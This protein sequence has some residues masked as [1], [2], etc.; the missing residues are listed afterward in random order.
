MVVLP[1]PLGPRRENTSPFRICRETSVTAW[2]VPNRFETSRN[3]RNS[4]NRRDSSSE[5][6]SERFF[7]MAQCPAIFK[8]ALAWDLH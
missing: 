6:R 1:Q 4:F 3:S 7:I 8:T 5:P 2:M